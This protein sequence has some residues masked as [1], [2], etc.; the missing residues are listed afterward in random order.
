ALWPERFNNKTNGVTQRRW[1]LRANPLLAELLHRTIGDKWITHLD[2][3]R[4]LERYAAD[5]AFQ[6]AFRAV[7]RR[8]KERLAATI[9]DRVR[10]AVDPGSLFDVHV[11]RIH[12]YKRQLLN[13]MHIVHQYLSIVEDG[14]T[15]AP[16]KTYV[17]AGKAAPG[18][19]MAKLIIRL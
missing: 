10:V 11:K 18:Y 16:P 8:N 14:R 1:L 3:L 19:V 6:E 9:Q 17:F 4:D 12:E 15:L 13:V 2:A 5:P 7:K